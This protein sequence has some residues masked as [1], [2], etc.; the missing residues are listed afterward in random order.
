MRS[1]LG[2]RRAVLTASL[3]VLLAAACSDDDPTGPGEQEIISRVT[4]TLTPVGGGQAIVAVIND[5]DGNGPQPPTAQQGAIVLA[6]GTTY[7]G[8]VTFEN[9]LENP[10]ENITEE[11]L[12]EAEAHRVFYTPGGGLVGRISFV[13]LDT[14][15][16]NAP[17]GV[18]FQVVVTAGGAANGTFEV[19]LS[20]YDE[21]PKGNGQTPSTETDVLVSFTASVQ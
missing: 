14:D 16:N 19:R 10:P 8:E 3:A 20:H 21:E 4:I 6:A 1:V 18:T 11:V 13:N 2:S 7:D 17:L 9:A 15:A 5:P 12:E